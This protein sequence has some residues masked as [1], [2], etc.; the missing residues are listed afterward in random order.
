[1]ARTF[2]WKTFSDIAEW[3]GIEISRGLISAGEA[4]FAVIANIDAKDSNGNWNTRY[5]DIQ[6]TSLHQ[7]RLR[8]YKTTGEG[9]SAVTKYGEYSVPIST[10]TYSPTYTDTR[11]VSAL[12][13]IAQLGGDTR[14]KSYEIAEKILQIE[15]EIDYLSGHAWR[16][17]Y[18]KS[19]SGLE[20]QSPDWEEHNID[21][22]P[23]TETGIPI[24]LNHRFTKEL[25]AEEGDALEVWD[26][27]T[28][29]DYIANK[30]E[31][32]NSDYWLSTS[33]GILFL[34][35]YLAGI[36]R[37]RAVRIKYRYGNPVVPG[38]ITE[39]ATL[40]VAYDIAI[41]D[42]RSYTIPDSGFGVKLDAKIA[43]WGKRIE[44]L[45]SHI[46]EFSQGGT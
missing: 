32:R 23:E 37:K 43:E 20:T 8:P 24:Y 16:T 10:S 46:R 13:Q 25:D 45:K 40:M 14:P 1:M 29:V 19:A 7:Y 36:P 12:L 11:K 35:G 39:L 41:S 6:G 4:G 9:E 30:T 21:L 38:F 27:A 44:A 42:D 34:R 31:G 17:R 2:T 15:D 28:Y 33:D 22:R 26:G 5:W 18:S 3:T